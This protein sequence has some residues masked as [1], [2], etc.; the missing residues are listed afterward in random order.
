MTMDEF[1]ARLPEEPSD[2][3][4]EWILDTMSDSELGGEMIL[5]SRE[6]VEVA[7][8]IMQTM[9]A[10]DWERREK[11]TVR[12]WGARC[13]C[14]ACGEDFTAGYISR[15]AARGIQLTMGD[16][17]QVYDGL[18]DPEDDRIITFGEHERVICPLCLSEGI[19]VRRSKLR[20][21][22]TY[23]TQICSVEV[24]DGIMVLLFW[25]ASRRFTEWG[26]H[27]TNVL[28]RS[29]VALVGGMIVNF[30]HTRRGQFGEAQEPAWRRAGR[31]Q[32]PCQSFYYDYEAAS[33]NKVGAFVYS[34][35]PDLAGTTG[36]K[37]GIAE[38]ISAGG[39]WPVVYLKTWRVMPNIENIV[40][41][42]WGRTVDSYFDHEVMAKLGYYKERSSIVE[43]PFVMWDEVKPHRMLCMSKEDAKKGW[44]WNWDW[45]IAQ[46]YFDYW[47]YCGDVSAAEFEE[48]HRLLGKDDLIMFVS[49]IVADQEYDSISEVVAYLKRQEA[50]G[51]ITVQE[52][53]RLLHDYRQMADL[54]LHAE[55]ELLWPRDLFAAHEREAEKRRI[56]NDGPTMEAF[57]NI[58]QKY[59]A[60]E[61][62]DG[63]LCIR[64]PRKNSDL[65]REG[66]ILRHCVGS[67]GPGHLSGKDTIFFVRRYRRP[68][69]SYYTLDIC[70]TGGTPYQVQLHGYGNERHGVHKEYRHSIPQKVKDFV[71]RWKR[72]IL[73]PWWNK[74]KKAEAAAKALEE[75]RKTA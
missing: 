67:Y 34:K 1:A 69:R 70:M 14:T 71:D 63:E 55:P 39:T 36:E 11:K 29:A 58:A 66:E 43:L 24:V 19:L 23:Q 2:A 32:D 22:R 54:E 61:W 12:K 4:R 40:K 10:E 20:N 44:R 56:K 47:L 72:E 64:L 15:G 68:E 52:G 37:T 45:E 53:C 75:R 60:L 5:F 57:A 48:Y 3:L 42:G 9:T 38:Y 27:E 65:I 28:P 51:R 50:R 21:G 46:S 13:S 59:A 35:V 8:E 74:Q 25:L 33:H 31:I 49:D 17:G 73:M 16:D 26:F 41:C 30:A 18:P 62:T 7:P 6:S